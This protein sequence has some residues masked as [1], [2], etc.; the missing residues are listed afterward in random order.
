[1]ATAAH[2][3]RDARWRE[4]SLWLDTL[5]Q[6]ILPRPRLERDVECDVAVVGAG[7]TGLWTAHSLVR[8]EPSLRVV[9]VEAEVA[10]YGA[11][12]R[13]GGFVSAGISGQANVYAA[14]AGP[15]S[16]MRA[17]RAMIDA[18]DEVG[19]V[20]AEEAIDCGWVKGGS[21]RLAT[22]PAQLDRLRAGLRTRRERGILEPDMWELGADELH[23]RVAISGVLGALFTP[24][25]ARVHPGR[26]VRGLADACVRHGVRI[27]ERSP[28]QRVAGRRVECE[29]G[30]VT[31]EMVVRATE[32]Y[33]VR[34]PG[35]RRAYLPMYSHMLA[36]E[37]LPA[38]A[39]DQIGWSGCETV[40][41][42]RHLFAYGQ[43]TV[44]GRI[45][46]GGR[47]V[48]Y[49]AGSAI[50]ERDERRPA[51]HDRLER[52]LR[53]WFPA[54]A[55]AV[56]THRWG[57]PLAVPRDWSMSIGCDRRAGLAWA[58]GL[59]GHGVVAANLCGR[60]LADLILGHTSELTTLPW[61]GH[62]SPR[63]EPEP[64]R[65]LATRT[66]AA[67]LDSADR[68]E[69]AGKSAARRAALVARWTPGR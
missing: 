48:P 19:R 42:Q 54:A 3:A 66:I 9:V 45:A 11:A 68:R 27:H 24:H 47:G 37:P 64:V 43:R 63:W 52:E 8:A 39:W 22:S 7:F 59:G 18:V 40:A 58:G 17:E 41:D 60:T 35:Y 28:A 12:G 31:A 26:L 46:I 13:N 62:E 15:E 33:T 14:R 6:P 4:R 50:R 32:S 21:L 10:G 55:G 30:G 34:L 61:V 65:S 49:R 69:D 20:V 25:C 2:P 38:Q 57:G 67:L 56:I 16:V 29:G 53:R 5:G 51:V 44:D 23:A 1:M 36:T